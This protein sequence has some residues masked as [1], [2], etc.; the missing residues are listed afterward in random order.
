MSKA[1]NLS[2]ELLTS[3]PATKLYTNAEGRVVGVQALDAGDDFINV[4]AAKAVIM[5]TGSFC[6]NRG[7]M[8]R[9]LPNP[10]GQVYSGGGSQLTNTYFILS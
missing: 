5:A 6:A 10:Q 1:E 2:V 3:T 9:Y 7:M 8:M 4:K